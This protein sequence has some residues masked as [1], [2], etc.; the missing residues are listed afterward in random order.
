MRTSELL[1]RLGAAVV[2]GGLAAVA[3]ASAEESRR[4][5]AFAAC[6][7]DVLEPGHSEAERARRSHDCWE[8]HPYRERVER[9]EL[10]GWSTVLAGLAVAVAALTPAVRARPALR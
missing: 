5:G 1:L 7:L 4:A 8:L 3:W 2:V 10:V 6:M 9:W